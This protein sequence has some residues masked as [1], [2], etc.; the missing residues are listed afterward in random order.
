[1]KPKMKSAK[2]MPKASN[3]KQNGVKGLKVNSKK[4]A[5]SA[6]AVTAR[7]TK[8]NGTSAKEKKWANV[9][10]D[11]FINSN[12]ENDSD[13]EGE[14][15][16]GFD[17][18]DDLSDAGEDSGE[19][20]GTEDDSEEEGDDEDEEDDEAEG[21]E[22]E[23][24]DEDDSDN[25]EV[26]AA[27]KHKMFLKKLES[28][29]PEF[30]KFLAE[31]DKELLEFETS[32]SEDEAGG[33]VHEA[34]SHL[35]EASDDSEFEDKESTVKRSKNVITQAM[36]DEWQK[37]LQS[38]KCIK[39][40]STVVSAFRSAVHSVTEEKA[41][42][43]KFKVQGGAAFNSVVRLCIV[44]LIPALRRILK[45]P[46][47]EK[48]NVEKCKSWVKVRT[49]VKL[50]LADVIRLMSSLTQSSLL[51]VILK[52][53]HQLIPF[54]TAF[55]KLSKVLC[56]KLIAVWSSSEDTIRV[57][58]FL[59]L[60][61]LARS[62][63]SQLLELIMKAMY[64]S[65]ARNC[66]FTSPS[67]WPVINFMRRSLVEI[68]ALQESLTYRHAFLYIRQLAIHL[69]NAI[70]L[71][72]KDS[73][74]T[75]YNWQFV[76]CLNLWSALLSALPDS[77]LLKPL[78]YPLV[79][80]A[81]GTI[82]LVATGRFYPLRFHIVSM[83]NQLSS[84]TGVFI[85]VLP[86][87]LDIL[88]NHKFDKKVSKVSMKPLDL[89][90]VLRV[91]QSQMAESGY[92]DAIIE[93]LYDRIL[94]TMQCHSHSAAF[95]EMSLPVILQLKSFIKKCPMANYT[96]KMKQLLDKIQENVAFVDKQ[97]SH[98]TFDLADTKAVLALENQIKQAGTPLST[99]HSSWKKMRDREMAIKIAKRPE[100]EK[101]DRM[102]FMK[103]S[104]A[105]AVKKSGEDSD[106][107]FDGL[108]PSDMSDDEDDETR[109]LLKEERGTKRK[110]PSEE[111]QAKGKKKRS[112]DEP[113]PKKKAEI[114]AVKG[115]KVEKV[116]EVDSD[117]QNDEDIDDEVKDFDM[118]DDDDEDADSD[119]E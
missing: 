111:E 57:L 8:T 97:R 81:I 11:E 113:E 60:L 43:T 47:D 38:D 5:P 119:D 87:M 95:P 117:D 19:E 90:C 107:E 63:P 42:P 112:T 20:G 24:G 14:E 67:T 77:Q 4:A 72:K 101:D 22:E 71:K 53:V 30:H 89:S 66:K 1:M 58:A 35:E 25:D 114:K 40:I 64:L 76:H 102:P 73:V 21:D 83:L 96:K 52:H 61:R 33:D 28:E 41:G 44:E 118:F 3:G 115:K 103:K 59:S 108:F 74:A 56:K 27:K 54:C 92:R 16:S 46:A 99:Y 75:V 94:E 62:Q 34:P 15:Q 86:F 32:D 104:E 98:V 78:L 50:Y 80:I 105:K 100:M 79:Q 18:D 37:E 106:G 39:T 116:E 6:V 49:Q 29:D 26:N 9:S 36:V 51:S 13:V 10:L 2:V 84:S 91:S 12:S 110:T 7:T 45:S 65:Y 69:R 82:N 88:Q 68:M 31:N 48:L 23:D 93:L 55:V 85:P 17:S 109:F 70:T